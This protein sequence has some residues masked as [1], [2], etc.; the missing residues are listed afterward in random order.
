MWKIR[1]NKLGGQ[2]DLTKFDG[3]GNLTCSALFFVGWLSIP[4]MFG[5]IVGFHV[6]EETVDGG[7]RADGQLSSKMPHK[8]VL[9]ASRCAFFFLLLFLKLCSTRTVGCRVLS[10][11][12]K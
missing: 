6:I 4:T 7:S 10:Q 9:N 1:R 2:C 3:G 5:N 11:V 12:P 8:V